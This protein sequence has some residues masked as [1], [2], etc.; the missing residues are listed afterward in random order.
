MKSLICD[1]I[2]NGETIKIISPLIGSIKLDICVGQ[3]VSSH[4]IIGSITR[5]GQKFALELPTNSNAQVTNLPKETNFNI[6]FGKEFLSLS[7]NKNSEV[8]IPEA[9]STDKYEYIYAPMDGLIYLRP[10]PQEPDFIKPGDILEY[11]KNIGLIEVMKNFYPLKYQNKNLVE[12][13]EILV[14]DT[15]SI[16]SGQA[17]IAVKKI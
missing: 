7:L 5:N 17:I 15:S 1:I 9:M 10:S 2:K 11:G 3:L 13:K 8:I 14:K 6:E 4:Q 16:K 12:V